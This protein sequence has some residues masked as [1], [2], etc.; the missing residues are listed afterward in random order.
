MHTTT[1]THG[2][3]SAWHDTRSNIPAAITNM[4][5]TDQMMNRETILQ[6]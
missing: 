4:P 1:T 6:S 3:M 2:K 5:A